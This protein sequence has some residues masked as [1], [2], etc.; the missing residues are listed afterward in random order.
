MKPIGPKSGPAAWARRCSLLA[1]TMIAAGCAGRGASYGPADIPRLEREAGAAPADVELRTQLGIAYYNAGRFEDARRTLT[2]ALDDKNASG[3]AF[4]FAGLSSEALDDWSGAR[5]AY[6]R[7]LQVG[8]SSDAKDDVKARLAIVARNELRQQAKS[9]LTNE[10]SLSA[11]PPTPRTVAVFPFRVVTDRA[12]L[13]PLEV[14]LADMITTDLQFVKSLNL[15]E[16]TQVQALLDEMALGVAGYTSPET[17]ARAGRMLRAENVVQG[18]LTPTDQ[19]T[20]RLDAALLGAQQG[21]PRAE[22]S[23]NG[24][25]AGIFDVEKKL[26]FDVINAL[27]VQLTE[28]EREAI[29]ENR[30]AN[31]LA[32]LAYG[33]GLQAVDRGDYAGAVTEFQQA[34]KLDPGFTRAQQGK[35][36]ASTL[37]AGNSVSTSDVAAQA[38]SDLNGGGEISLGSSTESLLQQTANETVTTPA[39]TYTQNV[40]TEANNAGQT[41]TQQASERNASSEAQGSEGINRAATARIT[42]TIPRPRARV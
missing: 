1:V 12:D 21:T 30:A 16:R 13:K 7:Y 41:T 26:V 37:Q 5:T 34:A 29:N 10:R 4:L 15:L 24:Q 22:L 20:I 36:E 39:V 2:P 38:S 28:A 33:R 8:T 35:T 25:L 23:G 9:A 27:G 32:L 11:E 42:I 14:A 18:V 17:G 3:P 40:A 19:T 31:L 6:T